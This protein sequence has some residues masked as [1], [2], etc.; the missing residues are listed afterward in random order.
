MLSTVVLPW[1]HYIAVMMMAGALVAELYLLRLTPSHE[2]VR[3]LPRV[4]LFYGIAAMVVF[5]TGIL[6]IYFG[7]KG[8]DW[9]WANGLMHGT[10]GVFVLAALV[11]LAPTFRFRRWAAASLA[12]HTLPTEAEVRRLR[13][14]VHTQLTALG[15]V[16][17]MITAVAKGYGHFG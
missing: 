11:S 12:S 16:A 10:I 13:P 17:L 3:L 8:P 14:L 4:D 1:I 6:R 7:G 2:T 5:A 15:L 9:Y